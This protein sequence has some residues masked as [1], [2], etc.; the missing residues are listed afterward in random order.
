M[1]MKLP[2]G[3]RIDRVE[4]DQ[5]GIVDR[6]LELPLAADSKAIPHGE[7]MAESTHS[8]IRQAIDSASGLYHRL[9]LLVGEAGAGK[10]Q[11]LRKIAG[12]LDAS[13]INVNM[14]LSG[15]L[16]E[17]T[18]NQRV[19]QLPAIF[20][21][22]VGR[23]SAPVVLDNLEVLFGH[24]LK[25]DPLKLLQ[26]AS[27]NKTVVAAWN[28]SVIAKRLLYAEIGHAEYRSYDTADTL[29]VPMDGTIK[30]EPDWS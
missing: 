28:G 6:R 17:L 23:A 7:P 25:Q 4:I 16:L 29:I 20:D 22:I 13:I 18:A 24:D 26:S 3:S 8:A 21:R 15:E 10:T 19:L 9:V 30:A 2:T 11:V 1:S 5:W 27:R 12:E 14:V